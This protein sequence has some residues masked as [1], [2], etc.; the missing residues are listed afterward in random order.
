VFVDGGVEACELVG[1]VLAGVELVPAG[2]A[3][4][5]SGEGEPAGVSF[6]SP[7]AGFSPSDGGFSLFE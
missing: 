7:V 1:E 6:F 2:A 5:E 3:V 4:F